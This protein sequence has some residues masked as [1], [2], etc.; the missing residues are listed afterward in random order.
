MSE[1][2]CQGLTLNER[3][4]R[5]VDGGLDYPFFCTDFYA[6]DKD[7]KALRAIFNK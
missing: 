5:N 3:I 2:S 7:Q 1:K 6:N 4:R